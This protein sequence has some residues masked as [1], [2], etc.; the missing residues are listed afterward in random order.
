[1]DELPIVTRLGYHHEHP[2]TGVLVLR[3]PD[4]PEAATLL[5]EMAE[6]LV[7]FLGYGCPVCSGD[8]GSANPPVMRC[9][10]LT[11]YAALEARGLEI[12]EKG[13]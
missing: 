12:R 11:A 4:G 3:N 13:A 6:A 7:L 5:T 8:C 9:P 1:M 10:M 2:V